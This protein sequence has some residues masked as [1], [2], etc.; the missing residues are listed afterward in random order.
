VFHGYNA[1]PPARKHLK[2][3]EQVRLYLDSQP[4][5]AVK[6]PFPESPPMSVRLFKRMAQFKLVRHYDSDCS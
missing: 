3:W 6:H 4:Y 2:H 5:R 1:H